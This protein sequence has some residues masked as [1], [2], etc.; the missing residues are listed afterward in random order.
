MI[1]DIMGNDTQI[2]SNANEAAE[3]HSQDRKGFSVKYAD[4][5]FPAD[6]MRT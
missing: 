6:M 1:A 4:S 3:V 5:K 2:F